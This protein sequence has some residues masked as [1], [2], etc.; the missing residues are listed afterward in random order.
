MSSLLGSLFARPLHADDGIYSCTTET[1]VHWNGDERGT[2]LSLELGEYVFSID[3]RAGT[4]SS[5]E[6][7]ETISSDRKVRVE[8]RPSGL[9]QLV[10]H[11]LD[12]KFTLRIALDTNP[13]RF[14]G[15][16]PFSVLTG[17]C[18]FQPQASR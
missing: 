17:T 13:M 6:F 18:V 16:G 5:Y 15:V 12:G 2:S 9:P 4:S 8:F 1:I 14:A 11:H 7:G 3:T 10:V